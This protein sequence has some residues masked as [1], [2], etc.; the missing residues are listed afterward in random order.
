MSKL[1]CL[2]KV[3]QI[4]KIYNPII[5][6]GLKYISTWPDTTCE[7]PTLVGE[8]NETPRV[9]KPFPSRCVL[10]PWGEAQRGQ[11]PLAVGL[12]RYKWYQRQTLDDVPTRKPFP[13]GGRHKGVDLV[14]VPH[15]LE[16][17]TSASE[18]A[19]PPKRLIY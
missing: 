9:W 2:I 11:Y 16:K 1:H 15:R 12:S 3:V 6:F 7:N 18:D 17:G 10:E 5:R 4:E 13:E 19:R 8:E 14:E